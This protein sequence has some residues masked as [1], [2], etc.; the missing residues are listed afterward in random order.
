VL[1]DK[2]NSLLNV[3]IV[4]PEGVP[5]FWE[6][7]CGQVKRVMVRIEQAKV[8]PKLLHGDYEGDEAF[9]A[10]FQQWVQQLWQEKDLQ[11]QSLMKEATDG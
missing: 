10:A 4:Y 2:F 6:F 11:I 5:S 3:T 7:L 8:P 1:G 9:R